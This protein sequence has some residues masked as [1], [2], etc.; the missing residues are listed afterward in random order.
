M[1]PKDKG[2]LSYIEGGGVG[3]YRKTVGG[4]GNVAE[5]KK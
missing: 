5:M 1:V 2:G 3:L 4:G